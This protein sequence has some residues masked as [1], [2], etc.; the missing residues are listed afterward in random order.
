MLMVR[1]CAA[2]MGGFLGPKLS[3]Q[4]PIFRQTFLKYG[5]FSRNWK[6]VRKK[7]S[8]LSKM[9]SFPQKVIIKVGMMAT[10]GN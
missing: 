5:W 1:V 7:L 9:D 10:E 2:Y 3:K 8:K 6:K 4:G